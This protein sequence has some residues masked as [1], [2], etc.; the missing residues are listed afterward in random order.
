MSKS[1]GPSKT[2][3]ALEKRQLE[4]ERQLTVDRQR[5]QGRA[6]TDQLA[7]R[8]KL[9]GMWSLLSAGF[10]GFPK[11]QNPSIAINPQNSPGMQQ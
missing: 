5:A 8:K 1:G 2:Q 11:Q 4:R 9:R 7:F 6:F 3:K 10:Q